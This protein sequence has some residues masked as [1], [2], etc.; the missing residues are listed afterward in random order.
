MTRTLR[1]RLERGFKTTTRRG[2]RLNFQL[3]KLFSRRGETI[4][5]SAFPKSGSTYLVKTLA[6]VTGFQSFFLGYH[7]LNE[8]DLYLPNLIDAWSMDTISHQHTRPSQ[9]NL[10]LMSQFSIRPVIL[11]RNIH[12]ALVSLTDHLETESIYT[13]LLDLP[14]NFMERPRHARLDLVIDLA[15]PWYIRFAADWS[16]AKRDCLWL[17]YEDLIVDGVA[18]VN[19]ILHF[20]GLDATM[21]SIEQALA[22]ARKG[23]SRFNQGIEGRGNRE[24][25]DNQKTRIYRLAQHYPD[26]DF[27]VIGLGATT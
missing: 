14:D 24:F 10:A 19:N 8:Q 16:R 23:D 26:T 21:S 3:K 12:D 7:Q 27:S 5:I 9:P 2:L 4:F 13:P 15:A 25:N 22:E 1:Q 11:T 18:T 6:T 17:R 20:H